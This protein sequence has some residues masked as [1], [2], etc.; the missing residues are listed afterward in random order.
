MVL[1]FSSL[2]GSGEGN[3]VADVCHTGDEKQ[4]IRQ[5][6]DYLVRLSN[7]LTEDSMEK[8]NSSKEVKNN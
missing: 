8:E 3:H 7:Q 1:E 2:G 5:L 4:Q 6:R